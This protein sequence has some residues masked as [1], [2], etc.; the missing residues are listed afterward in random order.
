MGKFLKDLEKENTNHGNSQSLLSGDDM[1]NFIDRTYWLEKYGG[2]IIEQTLKRI[3]NP[4]KSSMD[5][6]IQEI[7]GI[8]DSII[9]AIK[10]EVATIIDEAVREAMK[11]HNKTLNWELKL[12]RILFFILIICGLPY[13]TCMGFINLKETHGEEIINNFIIWALVV[14]IL[15]V[16]TYWIANSRGRNG[17]Y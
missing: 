1:K 6:S 11:K 16:I 10:D 13:L 2:E 12:W 17:K 8:R 5:K 14:F 7:Q 3:L 15:I 4:F 9:N